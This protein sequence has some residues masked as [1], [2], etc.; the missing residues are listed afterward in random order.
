MIRF[1][2][3]SIPYCPVC[4]EEVEWAQYAP[5]CDECGKVFHTNCGLV[6]N[7]YASCDSCRQRGLR[8]YHPR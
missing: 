2:F 7:N 6:E 4:E 3:G 8:T 5:R 1:D